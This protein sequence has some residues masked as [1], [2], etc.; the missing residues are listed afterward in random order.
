MPSSRSAA[1]R[2]PRPRSPRG[3]GAQLREEIL[4]AAERLLL[5][6]GDQHAVSIRAVARAVGVSSPAIYLHFADKDEL[7]FATCERHFA[8]LDEEVEAAATGIADPM[9]NLAE[10]FRAYVRFGVAD[11]EHYR[12]LCMSRSDRSP[13]V[14]AERIAQLGAFGHL[15]EAVQ[16]C[17]D[18]GRIEGEAFEVACVLWAAVHGVTSLLISEPDFPWPADWTESTIAAFGKG[19]SPGR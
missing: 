12:I 9:R 13:A 11:P 19:L 1:R 8:R 2:G 15:L 14:T 4:R 18:A 3:Q 5:E 10:R 16:R 6:S 7:L 17:I